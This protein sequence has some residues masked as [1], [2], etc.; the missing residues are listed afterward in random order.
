MVAPEVSGLLQITSME[1][2]IPTSSGTSRVVSAAKE[3]VMKNA[4]IRAATIFK[5]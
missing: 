1:P 2:L 3:E 5:G 4:V